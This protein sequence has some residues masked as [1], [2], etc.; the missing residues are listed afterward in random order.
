[1]RKFIKRYIPI[2]MRED[3]NRTEKVVLCAITYNYENPKSRLTIKEITKI[4]CLDDRDSSVFTILSSL[5][6]YAFILIF[7]KKH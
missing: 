4:F 7:H 5:K 1:M 6:T 3:L 2:R